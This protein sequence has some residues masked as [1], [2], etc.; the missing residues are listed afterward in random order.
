MDVEAVSAAMTL[1]SQTE[2]DDIEANAKALVREVRNT[3]SPENFREG[4]KR[5]VSQ[6]LAE[7]R[8]ARESSTVT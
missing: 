7:G 1:A 5:A 6:V 8:Q 4:F 3:Y 2:V